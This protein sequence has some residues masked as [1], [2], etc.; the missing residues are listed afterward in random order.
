MI[1]KQDFVNKSDGDI[2]FLNSS[3]YLCSKHRS[4]MFE[5]DQYLGF[6]A[7]LG[8]L[9]IGFWLM[10][11]LTLFA[12]PYWITGSALEKRKLKKEA[13]LKEQEN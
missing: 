13:K 10:L 7:F 8:I 5:F 3:L 12:I 11:F 6:L 9:T 4:I 2:L 1:Y